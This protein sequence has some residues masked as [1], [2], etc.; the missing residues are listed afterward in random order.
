MSKIAQLKDEMVFFKS[1]SEV[2]DVLKSAASA[3]FRN[4]QSRVNIKRDF[5]KKMHEMLALLAHETIY[6]RYLMELKN[7][8]SLIVCLTSDGGFLGELNTLL[9]N[10]AVDKV[11]HKDDEIVVLGERGARYREDLGKKHTSFW[12]ISDNIDYKEILPIRAYLLKRYAETRFGR[13]VLVYPQFISMSHRKVERKILLPLQP[14]FKALSEE[15]GDVKERKTF[16]EWD[17]PLI[18]PTPSDVLEVIARLWV[19]YWL[20]ESFCS[21]KLCEYSARIMHLESSTEELKTINRQILINFFRT[22]HGLS[23]KSIREVQV[24]RLMVR[25]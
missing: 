22:K 17:V 14:S 19:G 12:G 11:T 1:L 8:P 2:I 16:H 23:D 24:S 6:T 7:A 15:M 5:M 9:V 10:A 21:S 20:Y 13:I 3:Q 4:I 18:E 25:R